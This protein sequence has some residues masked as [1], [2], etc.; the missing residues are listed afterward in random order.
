MQQMITTTQA[1]RDLQRAPVQPPCQSWASWEIRSGCSGLYL[2]N[3]RGQRLHNLSSQNMYFKTSVVHVLP[4][5][6][7]FTRPEYPTGFKSATIST[8]LSWQKSSPW[9]LSTWNNYLRHNMEIARQ[10]PLQLK[11]LKSNAMP[12]ASS[13]CQGLTARSY[14]TLNLGD[15]APA[16]NLQLPACGENRRRFPSCQRMLGYHHKQC[17][18]TP[19]HRRSDKA[20]HKQSRWGS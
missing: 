20:G 14:F 4:Q 2:E 5:N 17:R 7:S 1:G 13:G 8:Y 16:W 6:S 9:H 18:N 10:L 11:G 12:S 15:S 3:L 19:G